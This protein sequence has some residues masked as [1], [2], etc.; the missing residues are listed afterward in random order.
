MTEEAKEIAKEERPSDK[1]L[2]FRA[3][4]AKHKQ[5]IEQE[6]RKFESLQ[7]ELQEIKSMMNQSTQDQDDD[8]PYV[9]Q[10]KLARKLEQFGK[11]SQEQTKGEIQSAIQKAIEEDRKERWLD[12]NKDF[13][14]V[15]KHADKLYETDPEL[16]DTILQ[17]P[18][19]FARQKLVY[20]NIKALKLHEEKKEESVQDQINAK[21]RGAHYQPSSQSSSPYGSQGDFSPAGQKNAYDQMKDLQQRMRF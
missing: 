5:D 20:K 10:K 8:D 12:N 2:N 4:E 15:L 14:D 21:R 3:L 19:G 6:K 17:M 1:E 7:N 18:D 11:K 13:Y 9:D 16:A